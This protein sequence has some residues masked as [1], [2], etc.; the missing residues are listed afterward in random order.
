MADESDSLLFGDFLNNCISK[1]VRVVLPRTNPFEEYDD[2]KFKER[3]RLSK[4]TVLHLLSQVIEHIVH[5][6]LQTHTRCQ[7]RPIDTCRD[8]TTAG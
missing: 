8:V 2:K 6:I 7:P 5:K 4:S 3:F 1:N